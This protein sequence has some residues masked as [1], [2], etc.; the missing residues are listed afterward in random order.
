MQMVDS[1]MSSL[2]TYYICSNKVPIGILQQVDKYRRH[3]LWRV[4]ILME[5]NFPQLH[6][7]WSLN[8]SA[9][10]DYELLISEFR[11]KHL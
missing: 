11:M 9:K 4:V 7:K 2:A 6:A 5:E 3:C 8:L 1:V 10:V